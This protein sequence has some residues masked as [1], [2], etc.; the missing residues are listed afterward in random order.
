MKK[1]LLITMIVGLLPLTM[2]A[3]DDDLYFV[4]KKQ[5]VERLST[6]RYGM[7]KNTYYSGSN[8]SV[9]EYNRR[10]V[11]HYEFID[12]DSTLSDTISFSSEK[13]VYPDSISSEDFKLTKKMARFDDYSIA[14]DSIFWAG[15][16]AGVYDVMWHSP[17]YYHRYGWYYGFYDPWYYGYYDPWYNGYIWYDPWFYGFYGPHYTIWYGGWRHWRYHDYG[18]IGVGG[19]R[20]HA[21]TIGRGTIRRDGKTYGSRTSSIARNSSRMNALRNRTVSGQS[22]NGSVRTSRT[23]SGYYN[24]SR[25]SSSFGGSRSGGS[26]FGG[27]RSSGGGSFSGGGSRGGGGGGGG[28]RMGGRR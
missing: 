13:G 17:W 26:S 20:Y 24:G 11:S 6:D 2:A 25:S 19:G 16:D 9:D 5:S 1:L 22:R 28:S 10:T 3:Q 8:R 21:P 15:Y 12:N 14:D 4:P 7:P 18:W 23:N 27:S